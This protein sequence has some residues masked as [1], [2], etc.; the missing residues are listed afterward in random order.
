MFAFGPGGLWPCTIRFESRK[1]FWDILWR[2]RRSIRAYMT[3]KLRNHRKM[4]ARPFPRWRWSR[5][6]I[7]SHFTGKR[8]NWWSYNSL[9]LF[10]MKIQWRSTCLCAFDF[11]IFL[12]FCYT[13]Y[14]THTFIDLPLEIFT[15]LLVILPSSC[16]IFPR[17]FGRR[18]YCWIYAKPSSWIGFL[19]SSLFGVFLL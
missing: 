18:I 7:F 17:K 10:N 19:F 15:V 6:E 12:Q 13:V 4:E 3:Y 9:G 1:Q 2:W 14:G 5:N 8:M 16:C 11:V